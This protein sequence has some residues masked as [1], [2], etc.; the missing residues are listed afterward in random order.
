MRETDGSGVDTTPLGPALTHFAQRLE[1]RGYR[2]R[3]REQYLSI[4]R[5]LDGYVARRGLHVE[6]LGE[7]LIDT[8]LVEVTTGRRLRES[9][10]L[11]RRFWRKPLLL[12]LEQLRTEGVLPPVAT[13]PDILGPGLGEYLAFLREHRGL[14][15]CSLD[16]QRLHLTRF[17]DYIAAQSEDD[18]RRL[19]IE[20]VDRYL[21]QVARHLARESISSVCAALRGFL[22]YL[23]MRGMVPKD[24]RGHVTTPRI[25]PLERMPRSVAWSDIERTLASVDRV[26]ILGHRD[27]AIMV[28]LAFGGLRAGD[29]AAL[30]LGDIDW[31]RDLMRV[32]R[33]KDDTPDE[34]PLVLGL[35]EP[36]VA[37]LR[38]RPE[39]PCDTLF[40]SVRAPIKPVTAN[41]VS[42]IAQKYLRLAGVKSARLGSHTLRHSFA[43]ELLQRGYSLKT[44]GD[45]LG[46]NH[47]EST[48]I[49]AKA[50]IEHL[51]EVALDIHGVLP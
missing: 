14:R 39:S 30:R 49:Y 13:A 10:R 22:G 51:R 9:G 20:Q 24:L 29:V 28:L 34:L 11:T 3:T 47:A 46:H 7:E 19:A 32:R 48:F 6:S 18:L 38:H 1:E 26:S 45:V 43:V 4:C 15:Q 17:L 21:V 41:G 40:L 12:L 42:Q 31:R 50:D 35:G 5:K 36:L 33:P 27:Y 37:Y 16:R 23:H 8:F 25:Y 2:E 44:I